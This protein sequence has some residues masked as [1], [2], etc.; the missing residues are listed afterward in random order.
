MSGLR[1]AAAAEDRPAL[2]KGLSQPAAL[3]LMRSGYGLAPGAET[4]PVKGAAAIALYNGQAHFV[5]DAIGQSGVARSVQR[6][7]L[8]KGAGQVGLVLVTDQPLD[9]TSLEPGVRLVACRP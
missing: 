8:E 6:Q 5:V 9:G 1:L 2:R 7:F 4:A 3:A